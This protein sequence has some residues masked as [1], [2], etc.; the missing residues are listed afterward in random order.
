MFTLY[1]WPAGKAVFA[2]NFEYLP[3][4]AIPLAALARVAE[5]MRSIP[6]VADFYMG[7]EQAGFKKRPALSLDLVLAQPD[8]VATI[9]AS[10]DELLHTVH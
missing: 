1:E 9:E 5:Q 8:A 7:V 3:G 6:K 2:L 4:G 10:I